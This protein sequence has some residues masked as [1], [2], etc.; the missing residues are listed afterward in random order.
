MLVLLRLVYIA[1]VIGAVVVFSRGLSQMLFGNR[2]AGSGQFFRAVFM[3]LVWPIALLTPE[4][5]AAL[6]ALAR[7]D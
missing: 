5:R 3:A 6:R 4:G 1:W 7:S 2:A